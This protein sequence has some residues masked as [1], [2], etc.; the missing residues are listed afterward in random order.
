MQFRNSRTRYG[1]IAKSFHWAVAVL[2]ALMLIIGFTMGDMENGPDKFRL[3]G[4]HKSLGITVLA[5]AALRLMW[6]FFDKPPPLPDSMPRNQK[7]AAGLAHWGLYALLFAMPLSGWL[8]S[9]AAG[10]T[11]SLFGLFTLPDLVSANK[12][13]REFMEETHETVATLIIALVCVH[14]AAALWHHFYHRDTVLR[15]MLPFG[16]DE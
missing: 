12:M 16:G 9:S 5:L 15:R 8:L 10:F 14:A 13:L 11:V 3:Y 1:A 4:L 2:I 6:R 7:M